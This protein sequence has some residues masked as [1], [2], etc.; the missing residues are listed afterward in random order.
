MDKETCESGIENQSCEVSKVSKKRSHF[1]V[2]DSIIRSVN[3]GNN[4][5]VLKEM[6]AW[7]YCQQ[8]KRHV[9]KIVKSK[10]SD[11]VVHLDTV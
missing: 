1:L 5:E 2:N 11:V 9:V 10:E 7:C 8:R 3:L 6:S 4:V